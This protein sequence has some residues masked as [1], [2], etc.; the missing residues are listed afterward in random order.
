MMIRALRTIAVLMV[1]AVSSAIGQ[2]PPVDLPDVETNSAGVTIRVK[3][4]ANAKMNAYG[5]NYLGLT[6]DGKLATGGYTVQGEGSYTAFYLQIL[7]TASGNSLMAFRTPFFGSQPFT[8]YAVTPN[9]ST[10]A[11]W[12]NIEQ[13]VPAIRRFDLTTQKEVPRSASASPSETGWC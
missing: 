8:A 1:M 4:L 3:E 10:L 12:S 2:A 6:A 7:S 13:W 5:S 11:A 9:G